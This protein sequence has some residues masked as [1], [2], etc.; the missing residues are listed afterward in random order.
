MLNEDKVEER[1]LERQIRTSFA[2]LEP[3]LAERFKKA[4]K[5]SPQD[6]QIYLSRLNVHFEPPL[7]AVL[8]AVWQAV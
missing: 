4:I 1:W 7:P 5:A 8:P 3:R 6:W 2:R